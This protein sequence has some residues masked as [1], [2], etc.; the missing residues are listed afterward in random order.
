MKV[1]DLKQRN[2]G[3]FVAHRSFCVKNICVSDLKSEVFRPCPSS[4]CVYVLEG[5]S[6]LKSKVASEMT[7]FLKGVRF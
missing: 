6:G 2:L 5:E 3:I 4:L 7:A 1:F